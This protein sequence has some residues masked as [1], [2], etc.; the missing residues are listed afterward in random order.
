[1][2]GSLPPCFVAATRHRHEASVADPAVKDPSRARWMQ[3]RLPSSHRPSPPPV[4]NRA[5][6]PLLVLSSE[7]REGK[8]REERRRG[9]E[10]VAR[11]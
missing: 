2:K 6:G 9:G 11:K 3:I 1:M 4:A 5:C 7:V 10:R 8:V